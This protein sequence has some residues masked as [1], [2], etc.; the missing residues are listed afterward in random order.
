ML[1]RRQAIGAL[2]ASVAAFSQT[3]FSQTACARPSGSALVIGAGI[4]GLSAARGLRDAG[5]TVTV[6]E[7]RDRIGGRIHTSRLWPDAPVDLGA[8]WIH[9]VNGN[10][11]T[12]LAADARAQTAMTSYDSTQLHIAP[13]LQATGVRGRGDAWTSRVV[14]EAIE[15]AKNSS[16]DLSLREAID[17]VHPPARRSAIQHAQLEFHLAGNY[18]QELAGAVAQLSA[19]SL[20][21]D[22]AF[23]GGDVLFPGG[24]DQITRFLANDLD[25][26]VNAVVSQV[27]WGEGSAEITLDSGEVHRADQVVVT[28]PLGVLKSDALRFIPDLPGD[29]RQAIER[30]GMGLLNKLFLR[31]DSV[32]WPAE[33]DWHELIKETPGRFSQWVSLAKVGAPVF[34]GFTGADAARTI[35]PRDDS[36]IVAEGRDAMRAMFGA[37]TPEPTA[38]Q[39]TRWNA[40]PFALGS[41]SF[42]A[43]CSGRADRQVL[44]RAE[45]DGVLRFAGEAC[46]S[47]Y[48]G[49]VHGALLSGRAAVR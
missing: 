39:L 37:R 40:D 4:A 14:E 26:R 32:F 25:I 10:P 21:D 19:W 6:L 11:L 34:L 42:N 41:Y 38:W 22:E 24:Y 15:A 29:K 33:Y 30:L 9:G 1:S 18:E 44:A 16:H 36:A 12:E 2:S 20:D 13:S 48:P 27:R 23:G 43:V 31:F 7:A 17:R 28:V 8:S 49:T 46:S 5:H 3:A 45:A 35:E 47:A